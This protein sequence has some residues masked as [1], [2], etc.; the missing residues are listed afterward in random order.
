MAVITNAYT[1][2]ARQKSFLEIPTTK[3]VYDSILEIIIGS[4]TKA[5]QTYLKRE[6][7]RTAYTNQKYDGTGTRDLLLRH[8]PVIEGQTFT[9]QQRDTLDNENDW[10]TIDSDEYFVD[11]DAGTIHW[12][13]GNF[14]QYAQ[15]YQV[16][17]TAGYYPPGDNNF[18]AGASDSLPLEI[19]LACHLLVAKIFRQLRKAGTGVE[20][21]RSSDVTVRMSADMLLDKQ[22]QS[23]LEPYVKRDVVF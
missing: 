8:Y 21:V 4:A 3:T 6:L 12:T 5:I 20:Q 18:S 13:Q 9:L 10:S 15:H 17:Y 2:L 23:L 22:L 19:E 16:S 14:K 1:T 11:Y 7:A